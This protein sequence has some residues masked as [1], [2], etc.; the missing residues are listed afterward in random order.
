MGY[1]VNISWS[2][3][4]NPPLGDAEYIAA[5]RTVVMPIARYFNPDLVLV[6]AGFDAAAGHPAPLG[7][8]LVSPA[9]FG[10]MT[11][12]LMQLGKGKVVLALE[13][14]YDLPAICDSAQECVRALLGDQ[15]SPIANSE[16]NR[17]P[18]QNAIDTL[19]KTI[20]IQVRKRIFIPIIYLIISLSFSRLQ[21]QHWPCVRR[22]AHT[23]GMSALEALKIEHDESD[24]VTAMAGLSMQTLNK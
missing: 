4:L 20:A 13:G 14:G 16:L 1:N 11:R 2:G 21:L 23:V 8:Y 9:C 18:C 3:A 17:Q 15:L 6:S 22:L 19:Q 7:G 10:Y 24:T 12:E 5:F